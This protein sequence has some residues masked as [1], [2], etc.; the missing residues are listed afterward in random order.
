MNPE[1][2]TH[3][4]MWLLTITMTVATVIL[5]HFLKNNIKLG[6]KA[7][8]TWNREDVI[9]LHEEN[10][11]GKTIFWTFAMYFIG[12]H[13]LHLIILWIGTIAWALGLW[14]PHS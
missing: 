2:F 13:V 9:K 11:T 8:R 4:Q 7:L 1:N 14:D 3:K 5:Y 10:G 12:V 6:F